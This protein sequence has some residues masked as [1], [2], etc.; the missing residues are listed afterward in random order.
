VDA[1]ES[2]RQ[3]TREAEA[4]DESQ[5][6][7]ADTGLIWGLSTALESDRADAARRRADDAE[8][9]LRD[10]ALL[11]AEA[12]HKLKTSLGIV[13]GWAR[14]LDDRWDELSEEIRREAVT[15]VRRTTD[16]LWA[17]CDA[18][19]QELRTEVTVL[20]SEPAR[21]DLDAILAVAT[22]GYAGA[23]LAHRFVH[24]PAGP[25]WAWVDPA[26]LQQILGH[27]FDNAVKYSPKGTTITVMACDQ[28]DVAE[29]HVIDE[30]I[31]LPEGIDV[32]APFS[33]GRAQVPDNDS[34]GG[35]GL[36]LYVVRKLAEGMNGS[37]EAAAVATGGTEF[38]VRLR[39]GRL[40]TS[41]SD[42]L[43]G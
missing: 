15:T 32:F 30:G 12:E 24:V 27:L 39:G 37:I 4:S 20:A 1:V 31:G 10:Q 43:S 29:L 17:H 41:G 6:R 22:M 16:D 38:V 2:M 5:Q 8:A 23:A 21:L 33:R 11:F 34:P 14:T 35:V 25:V 9:R 18:M 7:A 40:R 13:A 26:S 19:L 28:G 36:G 42:Q 3:P